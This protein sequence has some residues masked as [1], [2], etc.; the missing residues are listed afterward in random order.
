M[1]IDWITPS[2]AGK[3]WGIKERRVQTMCSNG[4]IEGVVRKGRMWLIPINAPKPVDGRT[5][6]AKQK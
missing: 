1:E 4:Q 3:K 5:K 2:E 6:V